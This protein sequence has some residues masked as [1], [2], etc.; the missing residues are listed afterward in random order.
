MTNKPMIALGFAAALM[1][2]TAAQAQTN[3]QNGAH[4]SN[5]S[6]SPQGQMAPQ[7][8]NAQKLSKAEQA[9]LKEAIETDMAEVQMG[10]LAQQK[11]QS[12]D[13]K[14]LGQAM[15]QDHSKN[16]QQAQQ[17]A[18]QHGMTPPS[19]PN[20]KQKK[21]HESVSKMSGDRFDRQFARDM[22]KGHKE[23]LSKFEKEAKGKGPLAL[24]AQQTV[25]ALQKHLQM[26]QD[27]ENKGAAV[28]SGSR[29]K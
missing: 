23:A 28:G 2:G 21:M 1:L 16:L 22:A 18:Q 17:L 10:Q 19:A 9:F 11:G 13:V 26:A 27:I 15:Q 29:M 3:M 14:Q 24:Y 6:M 25:P 8:Q 7:G 12:Q 5:R 20:A 4:P